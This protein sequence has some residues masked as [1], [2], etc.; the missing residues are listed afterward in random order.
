[1]KKN[2]WMVMGMAIMLLFMVACSDNDGP[3]YSKTALTNDALKTILTQKGFQF[4]DQ[5]RLL[6]DTKADTTT[7]LDLSG[8][9]LDTLELKGL[10]VLPHLTSVDLSHNGYGPRFDFSLLPE[11]IKS[12]NLSNNDIYEYPGLVNIQT[13]VMKR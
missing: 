8:T 10:S 3:S 9:K 7:E 1:M 12:V 13:A 6:L 5:G 2:K 11:Q 4:D